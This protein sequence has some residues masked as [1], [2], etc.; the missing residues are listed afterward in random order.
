M[1]GTTDR[2]IHGLMYSLERHTETIRRK[3]H[4]KTVILRLNWTKT[5]N[6][7]P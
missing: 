7:S 2:H 5:R 6:E 4:T 3:V 1:F